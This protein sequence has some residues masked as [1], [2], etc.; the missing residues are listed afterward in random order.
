MTQHLLV[1]TDSSRVNLHAAA[2]NEC[3]TK[4]HIVGTL[5]WSTGES[6]SGFLRGAWVQLLYLWVIASHAH[7]LD[8]HARVPHTTECTSSFFGADSLL[9]RLFLKGIFTPRLR[10]WSSGLI[11]SFYTKLFFTPCFS[12]FTETK[13]TVFVLSFYPVSSS[14][15]KDWLQRCFLSMLLSSCAPCLNACCSLQLVVGITC[16]GC[17]FFYVFDIC[18][19][20]DA[21]HHVFPDPHLKVDQVVLRR[22]F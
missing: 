3:S 1:T 2:C 18:S 14:I 4:L 19:L 9:F 10:R 17:Q 21:L 13:K 12:E 5:L 15:S 20:V 6:S 11:L 7:S 16:T 22:R 8:A